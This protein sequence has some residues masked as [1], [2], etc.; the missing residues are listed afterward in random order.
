MLNLMMLLVVVML[1]LMLFYVM[2]S[3]FVF[4][5]KMMDNT[6]I[7]YGYS[8]KYVREEVQIQEFS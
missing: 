4:G 6:I 5:E 8:L 1:L 7:F 2:G 3:F